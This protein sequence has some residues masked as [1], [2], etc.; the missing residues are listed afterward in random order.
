MK[1]LRLISWGW[2]VVGALVGIGLMYACAMATQRIMVSF[3]EQ[4]G[5]EA[6]VNLN[7]VIQALVYVI[8]GVVTGLLARRRQG[9]T[10]RWHLLPT[11]A[12]AGLLGWLAVT[13]LMLAR[14]ATMS[15]GAQGDISLYLMVFGWIAGYCLGA[16]LVP[17]KRRAS[18]VAP[19]QMTPTQW[20]QRP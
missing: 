11:A 8:A 1:V 16:F 9:V 14:R 17:A 18:D 15:I 4:F 13:A 19:P 12:L 20:D 7:Y 10:R 6:H 5:V 2:A 3:I